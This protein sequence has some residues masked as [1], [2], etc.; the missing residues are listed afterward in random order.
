M[1]RKA[2]TRP[3]PNKSHETGPPNWQDPESPQRSPQSTLQRNVTVSGLKPSEA[4]MASCAR[5]TRAYMEAWR[6]RAPSHRARVSCVQCDVCARA[7]N[8]SVLHTIYVNYV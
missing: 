3:R 6:R 1:R 4:V 5:D 7:A 8:K 2:Y